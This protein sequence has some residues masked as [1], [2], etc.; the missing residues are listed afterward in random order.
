MQKTLVELRLATNNTEEQDEKEDD[1]YEMMFSD[2]DEDGDLRGE[3]LAKAGQAA[4]A[5]PGVRGRLEQ[6]IE[7][8]IER[9]RAKDNSN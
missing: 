3:A 4:A 2:T 7:N 8:I 9:E 1:E 5:R 6:A